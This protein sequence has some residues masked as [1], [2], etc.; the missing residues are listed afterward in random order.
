VNL[1]VSEVTKR[2]R[3]SGFNRA[4]GTDTRNESIISVEEGKKYNKFEVEWLL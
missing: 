1:Q 4:E 3:N 2:Q